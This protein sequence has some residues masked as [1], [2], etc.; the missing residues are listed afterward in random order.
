MSC[1]EPGWGGLRAGDVQPLLLEIGADKISHCGQSYMEHMS[2]VAGFLDAWGESQDVSLGGF[3]HSIYGTERF[4]CALPLSRRSDLQALIGIRAEA[5]AFMNCAIT[6]AEFDAL[7]G[8]GPHILSNRISGGHLA[9]DAQDARDLSVIALADW[10]SQV[11]S[12]GEWEYRRAA[13]VR[14]AA[15]IG[16]KAREDFKRVYAN[17]PG[18]HGL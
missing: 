16:G 9:L 4:K 6:R 14:M 1:F 7:S 17:A 13:Y 2:E 15:A 12:T 5:L 3:F 8:P 18:G 10:L 11:P